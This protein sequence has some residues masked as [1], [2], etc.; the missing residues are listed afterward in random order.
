MPSHYDASKNCRVGTMDEQQFYREADKENGACFRALLGAW[1]KA[2]GTLELK[3]LIVDWGALGMTTSGTLALD[4][5]LRPLAALTAEI[6]GYGAVLAALADAGTLKTRDAK[7]ATTVL[8]L[9]AKP[10]PDGAR[11]LT[12]PVTAQ[13]GTLFVGPLSL[14]K[15]GPVVKR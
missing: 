1:S 7:L 14:V 10:A 13:N 15:L 6:E 4:A 12:V 11:V 5:E 2:G 8:D 9:L 3:S